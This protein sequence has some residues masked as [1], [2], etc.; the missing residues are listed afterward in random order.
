M[1]SVLELVTWLSKNVNSTSKV[2]GARYIPSFDENMRRGRPIDYG[3]NFQQGD[4]GTKWL[5]TDQT[6]VNAFVE[7]KSNKNYF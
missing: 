3:N 5:V 4:C 6:A 7:T 1:R 2:P